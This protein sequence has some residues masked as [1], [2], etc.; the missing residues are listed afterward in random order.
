MI[1]V[2]EIPGQSVRS[3]G[4]TTI[5]RCLMT[6]SKVVGEGNQKTVVYEDDEPFND[7]MIPYKS[8]KGKSADIHEGT[9]ML[10]RAIE[11]EADAW[12][13]T[14]LH[15]EKSRGT[16]QSSN[17][18]R[19]PDQRYAS[20]R[21]PSMHS[22]MDFP[23]GADYWRDSSPLG[24][25]HSSMNLRGM[26]PTPS[27]HPSYSNSYLGGLEAPRSRVQSMAGLSMWGSGSNYDPGLIQ[28]ML[29]GPIRNPFES[30]RSEHAS[31]RAPTFYPPYAQPMLGMGAPRN[32]VMSGLGSFGNLGGLPNRM[33]TFSLATTANPRGVGPPPT[34]DD[35]PNPSDDHILDVLRRY[36]SLQDLM[37]MYVAHPHVCCTDLYHV[38]L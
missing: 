19:G 17:G 26:G 21:A 13:T 28:P 8:F 4:S 37:T 16:T 1:S 14:S 5:L 36:L 31:F 12:E 23:P 20:S 10:M 7:S 22:S 38:S 30:P 6:F 2:G 25:N 27:L 32:S 34:R 18:R 15:S 29:T 11:Y 3:G 9:S 24:I 35:D 33:S